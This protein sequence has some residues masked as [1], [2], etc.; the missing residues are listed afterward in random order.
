MGERDNEC[1]TLIEVAIEKKVA[2]IKDPK[3]KSS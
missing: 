3:V 2:Q 1:R